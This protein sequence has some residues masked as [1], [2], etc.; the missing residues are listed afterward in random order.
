MFNIQ[1]VE[2]EKENWPYIKDGRLTARLLV[3]EKIMALIHAVTTALAVSNPDKI[4]QLRAM[5]ENVHI[6]RTLF[7]KA[8]IQEFLKELNNHSVV[9]RLLLY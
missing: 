1:E 7:S 4:E 8:N 6:L 5:A 9:T 2:N 3:N